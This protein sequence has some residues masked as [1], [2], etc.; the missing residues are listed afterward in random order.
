MEHKFTRKEIEDARLDW[1]V[2]LQ[3]PHRRK[4]QGKLANPHR[5][6]ERCC[7]GHAEHLFFG[8]EKKGGVHCTKGTFNETKASIELVEKLGLWDQTGSSKYSSLGYNAPAL[9]EVEMFMG[10]QI[11]DK[12]NPIN[13]LTRLNDWTKTSPQS[14]GAYLWHVIQGGPDTPFRPLTDFPETLDA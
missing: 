10:K 8:L 9:R 6:D 1:I 11:H 12:K 13:S 2:Y 7:L 5:G 3:N 14:I 4:Y